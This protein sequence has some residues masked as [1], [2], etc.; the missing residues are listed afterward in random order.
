MDVLSSSKDELSFQELEQKVQDMTNFL[1]QV[2][3][4]INTLVAG[5]GAQLQAALQN[6]N[7]Y[8]E[9]V[10]QFQQKVSAD[11]PLE[12]MALLRP[13]FQLRNDI[14]ASFESMEDEWQ[15]KVQT[16]YNSGLDKIVNAAQAAKMQVKQRDPQ[17]TVDRTFDGNFTVTN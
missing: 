11:N 5:A 17:I 10:V 6:V 15:R 3:E 2:K 14:S 7:S 9:D 1:G 13:F 4:N 12:P 8:Y 16:M